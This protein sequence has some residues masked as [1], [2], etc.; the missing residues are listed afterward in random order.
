VLYFDIAIPNELKGFIFFAQVIGVIYRNT[1]YVNRNVSG[2][3]RELYYLYVE[4]V[5]QC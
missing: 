5:Y 1:P 4:N 3:V 2:L